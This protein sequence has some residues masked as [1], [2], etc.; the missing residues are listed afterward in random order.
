MPP[1]YV[2]PYVK[3]QKND[4]ADAEAIC[5]EANMRFVDTKTPEQRGWWIDGTE[6]QISALTSRLRGDAG[7]IEHAR[8]QRASAPPARHHQLKAVSVKVFK[9][10]LLLMW[11]GIATASSAEDQSIQMQIVAHEDDDFLFMNPD[12][13]SAIDQG[14][15]IVTVY[16]TAGE[17]NGAGKCFEA[18]EFEAARDEHANAR[19][20][21]VKAAYA[22]MANPSLTPSEADNAAWT[23]ELIVPD[24]GVPW[25]HTVERYTLNA[26]PN[27]RLIFMNL[28]E[29]GEDP[30][31]G[32]TI[33]QMFSDPALQTNTIIPSCG[34][35]GS[36]EHSPSCQPDVPWQNYTRSEL[37]KVLSEL[38]NLY[39]PEV[40]R[41]LDPE[42]FQKPGTGNICPGG[43]SYDVCFDNLDHTAV[44]RYV[45]EVLASYHGP[46]GSGRNT[47]IHY[48]GYSFIN[49][50]RNIGVEAYGF[51][52]GA[53]EAY[54]LSRPGDPYYSDQI[55]DAYYRVVYE[56]YPSGTKWL[57]RAN[58][59]RLVA[60]NVQDREVKLWYENKFGPAWTGPIRLRSGGPIAP[61]V[62]L[63][64]RAD[65]RLQIFAMRLP[66][67]MEHDPAVPPYQEIIT[68]KQIGH[69]MAFGAWKS[70]G[71][72]DT[73][74]FNSV[75]TAAVDG[76][77][78]IFV[79]ARNSSGYAAY[80]YRAKGVWSPWTRMDSSLQ[81][82][83]D[84]IAAI[85]R[86]DGVIE[87]FATSRTGQILHYVQSGTS[88]TSPPGFAFTGAASAPTAVKNKDGRLEIFY[89]E[90]VTGDP[91]KYGRV[92]TAWVDAS[93]QWTGPSVLYGDAGVG[94][95]AAIQRSGSGHIMVFERNSWDGISTTRQVAPNDI[96][97]LQWNL[98]GG[99]LIEYPAAATD[100]H[101]R[102]VF[103][104][105]GPDNRLYFQRETSENAIGNFGDWIVAGN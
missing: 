16:V 88:F 7:H 48:K 43:G 52:R 86:N 14:L 98:R 61:Q 44:A 23:R 45:D 8:R 15:G 97:I 30:R 24:V 56:R 33:G 18:G 64:K 34:E 27:I 39:Q 9:I 28:R 85:T 72:P 80:T 13:Q 47:V 79:F 59:G 26:S 89:R 102:V 42:P 51:K 67:G 60:V 91:A 58:N 101:G 105:K 71:A 19:Q 25:P 104:V 76:A 84:G 3:R 93:G 54:R 96:F 63:L 82:L 32:P 78:R 83:M 69:R 50:P 20:R 12:I 75:P 65:G 87:V 95:V 5:E 99:R 81:D 100:N 17:A 68:A 10:A 103:M 38:I 53:G 37:I 4:A 94:P 35:Y 73:G 92:M 1:A 21:A 46:N 6:F 55:Y 62:T 11:L 29:D 31:G 40:I 57:E 70:I 2:K 74:Q 36:C 49:Y 90:A 77:G 22:K 66:L 41:T